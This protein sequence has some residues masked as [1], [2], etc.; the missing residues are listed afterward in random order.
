VV[1]DEEVSND[2]VCHHDSVIGNVASLVNNHRGLKEFRKNSELSSGTL[3]SKETSI[4]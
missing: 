1:L 4:G 2:S 3:L